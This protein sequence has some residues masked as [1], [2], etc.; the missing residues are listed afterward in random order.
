MVHRSSQAI[1]LATAFLLLAFFLVACHDGDSVRDPAATHSLP[2]RGRHERDL[3][4]LHDEHRFQIDF[5]DLI[6][7]TDQA[8]ETAIDLIQRGQP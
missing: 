1:R 6:T 5:A 2:P 7:G 3:Q 4:V 8:M